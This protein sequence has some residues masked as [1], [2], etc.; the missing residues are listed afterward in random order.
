MPARRGPAAE[1]LGTALAAVSRSAN[2]ITDSVVQGRSGSSDRRSCAAGAPSRP[3]HFLIPAVSRSRVFAGRPSIHDGTPL[4]A[5]SNGDEGLP[6][7]DIAEHKQDD[8]HG[9]HKPDDVVHDALLKFDSPFN[10]RATRGSRPV[11]ETCRGI[12]RSVTTMTCYVSPVTGCPRMSWL[13]G[14]TRESWCAQGVTLRSHLR[15]GTS[16]R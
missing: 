16:V 2:F 14:T 12:W 7:P 8:D 10:S 6:Q 5:F 9:S 4:A 1:S 3:G 15:P 11:G 13:A